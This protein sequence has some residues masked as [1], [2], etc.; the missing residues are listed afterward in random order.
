MF[1]TRPAVGASAVGFML[2]PESLLIASMKH[3]C[4]VHSNLTGLF[5]FPLHYFLFCNNLG[6]SGD[7]NFFFLL[8]VGGMHTH[9][10][11]AFSQLES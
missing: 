5:F 6:G 10:Y 1:G 8:E 9:S 11:F 3:R 7:A 4:I 2:L